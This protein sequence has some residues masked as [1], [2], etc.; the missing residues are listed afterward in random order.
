[1]N[2]LTVNQLCKYYGDKLLFENITFFIDKGQKVALI[3]KNGTGKS[4]LIK[5]F[6]GLE[7]PESGDFKFHKDIKVGFLIQEPNFD[8]NK[9]VY[10]TIMHADNP[11][12]MASLEYEH[13][14]DGIGDL[15]TAMNKMDELAAWD[16]E[17]QMKLILS[18]FLIHDLDQKVGTMSGGQKK[19]LA[20]AILLLEQPDL[21]ILDEPTNHLDMDMIEWLEEYLSKNNISLLM[22]THDRY[23]LENICNEILE[24]DNGILY[25]HK[26]N[27]SKYLENKELREENQRVNI[28]KAQNT[29]RKELEWMRRQPK[30]R[31]TK[32]QSRVDNFEN[33]KTAA[34]AKVEDKRVEIEVRMQRLGG[35]ILELHNI[36]KAYGDRILL[37]KFSHKFQR[38]E[39][40]GIVGRNGCGKSTLLNII[41]GDER[42]DDGNVVLGETVVFGYYNQKG[43]QLKADKKVID[44]VK[45]IAEFLPI[46]K[47]TL[48]A[49]QLL[50][51]FLFIPS[52]QHNLVSTLSGGERRR[53]YL[54]TILMKNPNFLILD[55]PT[56]DLDILTLQVLEDFLMDFKGCLVIVS[57]DRYF[58]DKLTDHLFVFEGNGNVRDFLGNYNEYR[59]QVKEEQKQA[60][61]EEKELAEK[62]NSIKSVSEKKKLSFKEQTELKQLEKDVE[63][64]NKNKQ[65]LTEKISTETNH[66]E[67]E[68][69]AKQIEEIII[70]LEK[71]EMR[72]LELS[73]YI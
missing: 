39:R 56:N 34:T 41:M 69:I 7:P 5:I 43:L 13:A 58:L 55:E 62:S 9:S 66:L 2:Y 1:M 12:L 49:S 32:A 28:E 29:F 10:Q 33:V 54:L 36:Q 70:S 44:V 61:R 16:Y 50:E 52:Q 22:I 25:K 15:Q 20:L 27:Y 72:W 21:F 30:A 8:D 24:L 59:L 53:L 63:L 3:A 67:L 46:G 17:Q 47:G 26:G 18:K 14:L 51:R 6:Q 68:K 45:D 37:D 71:K 65:V 64:L 57:H 60:L 40:V 31:T 48:S 35:K 23:F 38:G 19:R 4:S 73:E 42:Y 11:I